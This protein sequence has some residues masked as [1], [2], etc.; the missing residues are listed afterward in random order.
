[1][2]RVTLAIFF[3]LAACG[4]AVPSTTEGVNPSAADL[5]NEKW[6]VLMSAD[7]AA[8]VASFTG[9]V[10]Q[11][12]L[13]GC[14]DSWLGVDELMPA[15]KPSSISLRAYLR[16]CLARPEPGGLRTISADK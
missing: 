14:I 6:A 3:F 12:D 15:Q 9:S 2:R 5:K 16:Q 10:S 1:M 7:G 8:I 4:G 13:D 11:E